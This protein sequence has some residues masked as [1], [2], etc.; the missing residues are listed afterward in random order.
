MGHGVGVRVGVGVG[1]DAL[2]ALFTKGLCSFGV[3]VGHS[4]IFFQ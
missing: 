4:L 3:G 2:K 1:V